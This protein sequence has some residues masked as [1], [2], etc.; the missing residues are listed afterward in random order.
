MAENL[1]T[2][3]FLE[4]LD[5]RVKFFAL[6]LLGTQ[7]FVFNSVSALSLAGT[8]LLFAIPA[9]RISTMFLLKRLSSIS[10]FTLVIIALNTFTVS[11]DVLFEFM[12]MYAT[13]EG[14]LL[15]VELSARLALLLVAATV[16]IRTTPIPSMIDGIEAALHPLRRQLGP[17]MQVLTLALNFVPLLMQSAHQ[18]KKAQVARGADIERSML[19]QVRFAVAAAV[20]LFAMAFRSSEQLALA[21]ESRCYDPHAERTH[22]SQLKF[23]PTDRLISALIAIEFTV[24]ALV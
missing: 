5:P 18:I 8:V 16:F 1:H 7:V 11:G 17:L 21:M 15:G 12:D 19:L 23:R 22:Y 24:S 4:R 2:Q 10:F 3:S 14:L 6:V 13:R 9:S 20:P